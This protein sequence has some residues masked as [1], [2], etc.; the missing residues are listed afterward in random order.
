M[1]RFVRKYLWMIVIILAG[2]LF[3]CGITIE[4]VHPLEVQNNTNKT[5]E[6]SSRSR[7]SGVWKD[8]RNWGQV[9]PGKKRLVFSMLPAENPEDNLIL[10]EAR[11]LQ[12]N[13]V[14]SWEF[15]AQDRY[16]IVITDN[17]T[18]LGSTSFPGRRLG[19]FARSEGTI[20]ASIG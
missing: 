19:H 15:P 4:P 6:I 12:G 14:G 10:V 2:S 1:H 16:L 20:S 17:R 9:E 7:I 13:L 5:V 18:A 11:D 3:G 8:V